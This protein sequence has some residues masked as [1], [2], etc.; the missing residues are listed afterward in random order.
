MRRIVFA[1]GA[2][3]IFA[4]CTG[5]DGLFI[6]KE[7]PGVSILLPEDGA[8]FN[9][10]DTITFVGLVVDEVH[11]QQHPILVEEQVVVQDRQSFE[12]GR[13]REQRLGGKAPA[14]PR[15]VLT[16]AIDVGQGVQGAAVGR[17]DEDQLV[18][19]RFGRGERFWKFFGLG[20]LL[21]LLAGWVIRMGWSS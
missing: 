13:E 21:C 10:G 1:L 4:G 9:F 11:V 19:L 17:S 14:D 5:E 6:N 7:A 2:A 3:M 20:V 16:T 18:D 8:V 12:Q 15:H